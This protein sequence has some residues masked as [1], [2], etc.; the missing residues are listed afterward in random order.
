LLGTFIYHNYVQALDS[1]RTNE[2]FLH[3]FPMSPDDF[4]ADLS[5]ECLYLQT[6][7]SKCKEDS[8]EIDYVKVLLELED[9]EYVLC[10]CLADSLTIS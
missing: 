4:E 10:S 3:Q 7:A 2:D 8:V 9:A 1:I 6:A 5:D